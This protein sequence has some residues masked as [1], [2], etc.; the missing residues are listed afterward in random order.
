M[1]LDYN[2]QIEKIHIYNFR[3]IEDEEFNLK[4][5]NIIIGNNG[6]SK[7]TILEAI[8]YAFSPSYA[9]NHVNYSDF[10]NNTASPIDI[11]IYF[12]DTVFISLQFGYQMK[13]I[14]FN[15]IHLGI[16]RRDS[17]KGIKRAFN[18]G[19]VFS[20]CLIPVYKSVKEGKG[21]NVI[22]RDGKEQTVSLLQAKEALNNLSMRCFY[23]NKDREKQLNRGFNS[24][25]N[26][27]FDDFNWKFLL[28]LTKDEENAYD[29]DKKKLEE[30]ILSHIDGKNIETSI[31]TINKKLV[32]Y[33]SLS[34]INISFLD[35]NNPF[36]SAF[37]TNQEHNQDLPLSKLGSGIEMIMAL[38]FLE[39]LASLSKEN[40]IILIDE[41][42]LHLHPTLQK[43]LL[44]YIKKLSTESRIQVLFS[45]HSPYM[46]KDCC[47]DEHCN[48]VSRSSN[49]N[50]S[51][52]PWGKTWGEINYFTYN[53][54][55]IEFFN[56]LYG[57]IQQD[58]N[59]GKMD[60]YLHSKGIAFNKTWRRN[61]TNE[62]PS[63]L[64]SYVRNSLH[65]PENILNPK[66]TNDELK[67]AI[68]QL[69]SVMY[70]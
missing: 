35:R 17:S 50:K 24:S 13:P 30:C 7:T 20:H 32:E 3:G 14:P 23:F 22:D 6:T 63:T 40:I 48:L 60:E 55:T 70:K 69:L 56:E 33:F 11:D 59:I 64:A 51:I 16:K 2:M 9:Q 42:E 28:Q 12:S 37:L 44:E 45:T 1:E 29:S 41:P 34:P 18:D 19:F 68:E 4:D 36:N 5:L 31:G 58:M 67:L 46:F 21:W 62:Y 47:S 25:I 53:L 65:H 38:V 49:Y 26:S 52:F 43:Q 61:K 8:Q 39:T 57:F 54:P 10:Y 15:R 27:V 66:Y